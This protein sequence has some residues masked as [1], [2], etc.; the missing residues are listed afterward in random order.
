[1]SARGCCYNNACAESFFHTLKVEC[2]YGEGLCQLGNN[3]GSSV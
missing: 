2:I 1:M 3:A